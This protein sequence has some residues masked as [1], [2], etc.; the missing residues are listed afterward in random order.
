MLIIGIIAVVSLYR[1]F[2]DVIKAQPAEKVYV[3]VEG[4]SKIVAFDPAT[5]KIVAAIDLSVAHEGGKLA[6]AP[7]N[8]QVSPDMKTVWVTA[9]AKGH[10]DHSSLIPAAR[11]H[12]EENEA[13]EEPDEVIVINPETDKIVKRSPIRPGVH[14]AHVVFAPDSSLAL[15]TAQ[16]EDAVYKINARTFEI[17][18]EISVS[19]PRG[20]SVS[21][22]PHGIRVSPDGA[23]AYI[24]MLKG[25]SLGIL[26]VKTG[27]FSTIPLVGAAVQAGVTPDGK[28]VVASVYD[29][30]QLAVYV[31]VEKIRR[32]QYINLPAGAK[33][34]IQ[35]YP[36]PDSKF[37][38]LADQ[39]YY[40]DQPASEWV[41]K[42]DLEK[43][44]VVKE[45][46]AGRGPHGVA[47]S[48]DGA[49]V[50][51]TNLLSGDISV[52]NT[53]TDEEIGRI[54]VGKEPNGISVWHKR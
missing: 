33:G 53:A 18:K 54:K 19:P 17:E 35:M 14:L 32:V 37:V 16:S 52:I 1:Y 24:A 31:P 22:E 5:K 38:Y 36:T 25:K 11:A 43:R 3:A 39:G 7:H 42:I 20:D 8:V 29:T 13:G 21:Q 28:F 26:D 23:V 6:Y 2:S 15:V 40:F 50:Y 27:D 9:N 44:E 34:P 41:Y 10:E 51:V 46:K 30:K 12:G 4:E 45:I 49:R 48:Q 47:I